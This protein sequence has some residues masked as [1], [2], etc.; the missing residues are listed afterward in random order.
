MAVEPTNAGAPGAI[1]RAKN[2]LLTPKLEWDRIVGETTDIN[3]L[4]LGYVLPLAVIAALAAF[5]GM[6]LF[7]VSGFGVSYR[8]PIVTGAITAA[9][10]IVAGV[11]GVLLLALITNALAPSFGSQQNLGQAHKLAAHEIGLGEVSPKREDVFWR[12]VTPQ[13]IHDCGRARCRCFHLLHPLREIRLDR[14]KLGLQSIEERRFRD[15]RVPRF[16]PIGDL[17]TDENPKDDDDQ[18]NEDRGPF[19]LTKM[20]DDTAQDHD[21]TPQFLVSQAHVSV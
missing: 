6:S 15:L 8:V 17:D 3:K 20:P 14:P 4:Y 9:V 1:E 2:I 11:V 12:T 21:A 16:I 13:R 18:V 10:Q 7:G 19:L 5:I